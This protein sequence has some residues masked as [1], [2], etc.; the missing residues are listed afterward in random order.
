VSNKILFAGLFLLLT[1]NFTQAVWDQQHLGTNLLYDIDF[2]PRN[3][4]NGFACGANS[5][6]LKTTD[7][8]DSWEQVTRIDPSGNF[9]AIHFPLDDRGGYI[10]CDSGNIQRT[11]DGDRWEKIYTGSNENLYGI[12]FPESNNQG[13]VVGAAGA[14]KRTDDMGVH[15]EEHPYPP[16]NFYD[17]YFVSRDEGWVVGDSGVILHT[18]DGGYNWERQTSNVSTSLFGVYFLSPINGW[19]VGASKTFLKTDDGGASWAPVDITLPAN[20]DLYSVI[21]PENQTTGYVCGT[22]GKIAKTIDGGGSWE[23]YNLIYPFYNIE[24]PLDDQVGWVCGQS[25]VIYKTSDGGWIE[26]SKNQLLPN[27]NPLVGTPN[28]FRKNTTMKFS[29]PINHPSALKIYDRAGCLIRTLYLDPNGATKWDGKNEFNQRV[30]PG[31]Y[32]LEFK[33]NHGSNQ[34]LK[35]T[36][37]E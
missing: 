17:V 28:P 26:E 12:H 9:N 15:W 36:V 32:L 5:W 27:E 25:E 20:I 10:A 3:V 22:L 14:I 6:F 7:G 11:E 4:T 8:G 30:S 2:P 29:S 18:L 21:F 16:Y 1:I 13:Y 33:T 23:T 24:F 34:Y 19:V 31:V 35:L 37:L